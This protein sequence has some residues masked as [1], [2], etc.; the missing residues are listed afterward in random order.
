MRRKLDDKY[1]RDTVRL[2]KN[3]F[4]PCDCCGD[5]AE[6]KPLRRKGIDGV[7]RNVC[8]DCRSELVTGEIPPA[9]KITGTNCSGSVGRMEDG[10][11]PWQQNAVGDMEDAAGAFD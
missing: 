6:G 1:V 7:A 5:A 10:D 2:L 4:V 8:K 11:Y 9:S 3:D